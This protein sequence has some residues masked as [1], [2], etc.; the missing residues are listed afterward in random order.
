MLI[1]ET[2]YLMLLD[3]ID[4]A[5]LTKVNELAGRYGLKPYDFV[6]T[7]RMKEGTMVLAYEVPASGTA[8]KET[9]FSNM[10][11]SL[12]GA[13]ELS[14]KGTEQEVIDALDNAIARAPRARTKG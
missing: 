4:I 14:V 1:H 2:L 11:E 3:N 13:S 7:V 5:I 6:A 12:G 9:R 8:D 10:I